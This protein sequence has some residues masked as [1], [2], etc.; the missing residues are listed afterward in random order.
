MNNIY[1]HKHIKTVIIEKEYYNGKNI[2]VKLSEEGITVNIE[3][4]SKIKNISK[5]DY[6]IKTLKEYYQ[7]FLKPLNKFEDCDIELILGKNK[8]LKYLEYIKENISDI[9]RLITDY[10]ISYF[11]H[12]K[13]TYNNLNSVKLDDLIL[14]IP[15]YNH[16]SVT[17][18]TSII[19][20]FNFLTMK[21]EDRKRLK[22]TDK[23]YTLLEMDFKSC[24]P[25]FYIKTN[26]DIDNKIE[27][28]YEYIAKLINY[29]IKDRPSFKR[30]IIS[31]MYGATNKS[32]TRLSGIKDS[33][34]TK[35]KQVLKIEE[36]KEFLE[37]EFQE[38]EVFFN[39]Y[40]RPILKG[41]NVVN[42]WIQSSA[43]DFCS[44]AFGDFIKNNDVKPCFLIHDSIT[45]AVLNEDV[46][47]YLNLSYLKCPISKIEIP[48]KVEK[49]ND[50]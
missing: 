9:S 22:Y 48:V 38:K 4:L 46:K 29:K 8:S 28:V 18:R 14:D 21:K 26:L 45:F 11:K 27:D 10:H 12:R 3:T 2:P 40:G 16:A 24:E 36:T 6:E 33:D 7:D 30:G 49:L 15:Q 50:S 35:I 43:V 34:I 44:F 23:K 31:L 13:E 19:K 1:K 5:N 37:K 20:G 41:N 39:Y 25:F 42:Y 47:K 32:I 17:G